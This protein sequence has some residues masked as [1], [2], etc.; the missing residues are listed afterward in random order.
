M[1]KIFV[2]QVN[3]SG[4]EIVKVGNV[5]QNDI[6]ANLFIISLLKNNGDPVDL[7]GVTNI[8]FT[9]KKSN[10]LIVVDSLGDRI[11]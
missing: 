8:T 3:I 4:E 10:G 2:K 11:S 9:V 6:N 1:D 7:T 5:V